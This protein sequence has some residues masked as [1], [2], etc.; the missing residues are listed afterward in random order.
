MRC[1]EVT[2]ELSAPTGRIDPAALSRHLAGCPRC[3]AWSAGAERFDRIWEA[4]RPAE[5]S[6]A[7]WDEVWAAVGNGHAVRPIEPAAAGRR[8]S[9]RR[10]IIATVA[11]AQA[12]A[13]L[14]AVAALWPRPADRGAAPDPARVPGGPIASAP[15]V[16]VEQGQPVILRLGDGGIQVEPLAQAEPSTTTAVTVS[17]VAAEVSIYN[18]M[19][20][21]Q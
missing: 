16:D 5:P 12:A 19:E 15:A 20:S 18:Y 7:A 3:A 6:A 13:I 9:R 2:R 21:L 4:T 10:L 14:L 17:E 11:L 1:V 8:W